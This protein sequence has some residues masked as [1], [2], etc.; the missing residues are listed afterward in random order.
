MVD[1]RTS[2]KSPQDDSS[3]KGTLADAPQL[4]LPKGGG[5]IRGIG[6]KFTANS[7]TGTGSVTIPIAASPARSGFGPSLSLAYN[8]GAANNAFGFGWSV[9]LPMVT[10]KT[11]KGLPQYNDAEN[12]DVFLLSDAEDLMPALIESKTGWSINAVVRSLYGSQY[13]VQQYR[14][15]VEGPFAR[16]E[17]WANVSDATDVFWRTISRNNVNTWF[18]QTAASRIADPSDPTRIFSWLISESYDDEGNLLSYTWKAEDSEGVD[19]TQAN[20]RNRT[21]NSRSAQRYIK[22]IRYG[23]RT[24]YLPSMAAEQ[25]APLPTDWCFEVVFD[26]GEHDEDA[27]TPAEV[28]PWGCR[29]DAFSTYRPTF[30]V[31]TYRLCK[32]VLM[33]HSFPD[34]KSVG[35]DS[36]VRSFDLQHASAPLADPTQPFY[37][38]LESV[39]QTGYV[40]NGTGGYL[41]KSIPPV[42]FIYTQAVIDETVRDLDSASGMNLPA[43]IDS[44]NYRWVD[45]DS[46]GLSGVLTEQHGAWYYKSNLSP[47]NVQGSGP[48]AVTVAQFAPER[49]VAKLPSLANI[50]GG[51][52]QLLPLSGDGFLSLVDLDK[53]TPGYYERTEEYGWQPFLPFAS[54]PVLDWQNPNLRFI[55]LTGDGFA[56]VLIGEDDVFWWHESLSTAGFGPAQRVQQ[57]LDEERGPQLVFADGTESIFLA[58]MSGD[59]LTDL[60]RIRAGEVC[61]WPNLGYGRFGAKV[62]MDGVLRLDRQEGFDA[63]RVRLADIDGSGASDLIYFASGEVHLYFSQSGNSFAQRRV[64]DRF[65]LVDTASTAAVLDLLG[66]GTACLVWSSP[67]VANARTQ[68][69][70]IDLMGGVKPHLLVG[71]VNNL[72]AETHI[73]YAPS[74]KFYVE[75][76]LAGTPWITRLPFPVQVVERVETLDRISRNRFVSRYTYHHGYFDGVEREFRGFARVDQYDSEDFATLNASGAL[77]AAANEDAASNVPPTLTKTWFHTGFFFNAESMTTALQNEYYSEGDPA[78]GNAGL[79]AAEAQSLFLPDTALPATVLLS[80]GTRIAYDLSGEEMRESCR[81]LRGS[82]LRQEVYAEDSTLAADRPYWTSERNYTLEMLQPQGP[83]PYAVF[84]THA[85]ETLD[86]HYERK[87]YAVE[88]E[89]LSANQAA[90]PDGAIFAADP[91]VTHSITMAA[92][93]FGNPLETVSIGY[94]RRFAD[95]ALSAADQAAQQALLLTATVN[96][97]T[98]AILSADANRAPLAAQSSV[99]QLYQCQPVANLPNFTNLFQFAE[100]EAQLAAASDGAHDLAYEDFSPSGLNAGQPYRRLLSTTRTLY[101]PDDLGQ[102]AG[103]PQALLPLGILESLALPGASY[104]QALTPGLIAQ[105]FVRNAATLLP[106]PATVLASTAEDGGGYV[107]L[108]GN[109]NWWIPSA[110]V[111]YSP[112][113]GSAAEESMAAAANFYLPRR[114]VDP[115]GNTTVV[116]YEA[117]NLFVSSTTD[118]ANNIVQAE[119]DYR[120]LAPSLVTDANNNQSAAAFD[121]LGLVAGTAVMGKSGQNLGDSFETFSAQL[122]QSQIDAFFAAADPHTLAQALLGTAT[123]C[124]VYNLQE[125]VESQQASPNDPTAWQPVFAAGIKREI[126]VSAL[127]EGESSPIQVSFSYFDGFGRTIQQ[128]QQADPG[129]VVE[130]GPTVNPRWVASGWTIFDNKGNPVRKYEPFF[131]ALPA[132]G[133][134]FEFGVAAGVSSIVCYDPTGRAVA[135]AHPNQTFSKVAFDPWHQQSWDVNDT[136]LI[137]DPTSDPDV[138]DWLARLAPADLTPTW[139]QQRSGGALGAW[140]QDAA[141]KA[142]AHA[143]TPATFY[144][145]T[146]GRS[147]LTVADNAA[148]GKYQTHAA[149]DIQSRQ[150]SVTDPLQRTVLTA[151]YDM[152]GTRLTQASMEAGQRWQL[153]DVLGKTIR[154]WDSRGHNGRATFDSL[155]R[156]SGF[157]VFGTDAVNSDS[158]T[159]AAEVCCETTVYGE[160]QPGDQALNLRTRV[161]QTTD[162]SGTVTS[163]GLNPAT[164][165]QEAYDFKGNLLRGTRAFVA[166]PKALTNWGAGAPPMSASWMS[167]SVYDALNRPTSVTTPDGSI[168]TPAYN[169]RNLLASVSV[170]LRGAAAATDFVTAIDYNA[171]GQRLRI[172]YASAGTNTTYIYDVLT[173]RM[174]GLT[175]TRPSFPVNQQTVQNLSYAYDPSGNITHIEDDADIQNTVFFRNRRVDPSAGYTFDAIYRLIEATGREQLGLASDGT[176]LAP[177]PSSYNDVPRAGLVQP[178]DGNALGIY[179]EQY[180]YDAAGNFTSFIHRGSNPANPGWS[181]TY[182]YNEPS[183]LNAAQVSNR[184]S[185][186]TIAGGTPF[187]EKYGYDPHGNMTAMPQLQQMAWD[188][189]NR[190]LMTQRQAVN[191]SDTAGQTA[192]GRQTWYTY[193]ASGTRARKSNFSSAG[194]LL[195]ERFY[196]GSACEIYREYDSTGNVTL[197]RQSLHVMDDKQRVAL[198]ETVTVDESAAPGALPTVTQRY[199]FGNPLSSALLELDETGAVL[200]YEEYY[201]FGSTSYQAGAGTAEVS[202]KRYRYTG[203]ERDTETGLYYHGARYYAAWIGRW[204][205]CDP[206]GIKDG[207]NL[208]AYCGNNPIVLHDPAGTDGQK[209]PDTTGLS[210]TGWEKISKDLHKAAAKAA[211]FQPKFRPHIPVAPPAPR[212]LTPPTHQ[213]PAPLQSGPLKLEISHLDP[214]RWKFVGGLADDDDDDSTDKTDDNKDKKDDSVK[215]KDKEKGEETTT[216]KKENDDDDDKVKL[217]VDVSGQYNPGD[218]SKNTSGKWTNLP[219]FELQMVFLARNSSVKT[220]KNPSRYLSELSLGKEIS[221]L[222]DFKYHGKDDAG[223]YTDAPL[224]A[225]QVNLLLL[226]WKWGSSD[227]IELGFPGQFGIDM[228][229][230]LKGQQAVELDIHLDPAL[231]KLTS[232]KITFFGTGSFGGTAWSPDPEQ[233][234]KGVSALSAGFGLKGSW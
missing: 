12:S 51:R 44:R 103:S 74:T 99:Y 164:G 120:V 9:A 173:F 207:P 175:T 137:G 112:A 153:L 205:A 17:R 230:T 114:Y 2:E 61:Y 80:D 215:D 213:P 11:D 216:K 26:Y 234:V 201:P 111:Y 198:V 72:G 158:R 39:S 110:R 172:T 89:T 16:I 35:A 199:Q 32:R 54:L 225:L 79:N 130:G 84:L 227:F 129:P 36:L 107:D 212:H 126:H 19:L 189:H 27:P 128:K 45:L 75:D 94:G 73:C 206:I 21:A 48:A 163:L 109:G 184:L 90:P 119:Y 194:V 202:L 140:E 195:N 4:A 34:D 155:R 134:Q 222:A 132:R 93:A 57:S 31:R 13:N 24:P 117:N 67:L 180:H 171:R 123:A 101:R 197:E 113:A 157:Y 196:F 8:S 210:S 40:P 143:N 228:V 64:L 187:V 220:W 97:Y 147:I 229:G 188:Y 3:S 217:G 68:M 83:N 138:G 66:N 63:R 185:T 92:D 49:L 154:S 56:D 14:P 69:R 70:Y 159:L 55:D 47:A 18:G 174:T 192:Q 148:F 150:L 152:Q 76:K 133:H 231:K 131:S 38:Y 118:A 6:E 62:T 203:K 5:A 145:D 168:T 151:V 115:F 218:W 33:F 7:V 23:N 122:T 200:T 96:T 91:R 190:L 165:Q 161:Y 82:I 141:A 98:N 95:P 178:G 41:S 135:A 193:I 10:R 104:K 176:P 30:E 124:F 121:S 105:V 87:L 71:M 100:I 144:F 191:G 169:M 223:N 42:N 167:S 214:I 156:P 29:L 28:Q 209:P 53:P 179:D 52:Q 125:Y 81:A 142:A 136:V 60:V 20:E 166:D 102:A 139:Y 186:T 160:G 211:H 226:A 50:S 88:G 149:F 182:A 224:F 183:Q 77:P 181:R 177:A 233:R 162:E 22:T 204:T 170:N 116:S 15:R 59:G 106:T 58:D 208:Y 37:S 78:T 25:P 86:M 1:P 221:G 146:L 219:S 108:D 65:P 46:E 43:G 127:G 85:R 232:Q